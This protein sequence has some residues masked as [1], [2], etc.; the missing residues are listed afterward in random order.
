MQSE[1]R[2]EQANRDVKERD[3]MYVVE[4]EMP[5]YA[6]E[7]IQALF[8][9]GYLVVTAG[10]DEFRKA[11]YIGRDVSQENI[12]AAFHSGVLKCMI[13][14]AEKGNADGP[15]EIESM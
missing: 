12:R 8:N 15:V 11:Y 7:D 9:D 4:I 6:K 1:R 13:T 14:K 2:E 3:N 10:Q 5:E